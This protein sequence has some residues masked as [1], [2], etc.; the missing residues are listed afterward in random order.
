MDSMIYDVMDELSVLAIIPA[1][2]G[3]KGLPGKNIINCAGRP[4][5]SW[6]IVAAV[7]SK[8]ITRVV[9]TTDS[10]EIAEVAKEYGAWVPFLRK[11]DL[12][13]DDSS[14]TDV[15]NDV[16]NNIKNQFHHDLV[17]LLQPT[18]P[19]RTSIHIDDAIDLYFKK[20]TGKTDT[21][22]SI[23]EVDSKCLLAFGIKKDSGNMYSHFGVDLKNLRRQN[24]P[25]CYAPNGAIY[26]APTNHFT[27]FYSE[28]TIPFI[29]DNEVSIDIDYM[30]DL[31]KASAVLSKNDV[32]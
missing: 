16:I 21:L 13:K 28:N 6:S 26:I 15:V 17:I 3:S 27:G 4:L 32:K 1:R 12:A 14:I 18:S 24:L 31:E 5:I 10:E 30:D 20:K 8:Y 11:P 7:E 22:V 2:S 9:V 19:L 23:Y 29:M 25:K